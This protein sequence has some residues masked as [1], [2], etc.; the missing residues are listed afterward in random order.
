M[1]AL[2]LLYMTNMNIDYENDTI[3]CIASFCNLE[4]KW[5]F[6]VNNMMVLQGPEYYMVNVND[7]VLFVYR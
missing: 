3:N 6:Y 2:Q 1:T 7:E 5:E 4:Q